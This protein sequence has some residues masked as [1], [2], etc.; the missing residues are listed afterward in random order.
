MMHNHTDSHKQQN[1]FNNNTT[2]D[3]LAVLSQNRPHNTPG[4]SKF[5]NLNCALKFQTSTALSSF[6]AFSISALSER[7]YLQI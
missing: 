3:M 4:F 1:T 6:N 2:T 7:Q 5:S